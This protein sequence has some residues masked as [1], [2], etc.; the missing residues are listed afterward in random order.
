MESVL[1]SGNDMLLPGLSYDLADDQASYVVGRRQTVCPCNVP[2]AGPSDVRQIT[3]KIADPNGFLDLA[4]V[5]N[6]P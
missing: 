3:F 2:K 4:S 5:F 6:G 1:S